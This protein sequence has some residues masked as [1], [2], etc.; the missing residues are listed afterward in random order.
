MACKESM[1]KELQRRLALRRTGSIDLLS[2]L[3]WDEEA[4]G[5]MDENHVPRETQ[6]RELFEDFMIR[7]ERDMRY[8]TALADSIENTLG[9]QRPPPAPMSKYER[10]RAMEL[11]R[12]VIE[13]AK[14]EARMDNAGHSQFSRSCK[15][16]IG[17]KEVRK[18]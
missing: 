2:N 16:F 17:F 3:G 10:Q 15:A 13:A 18:G 14:A 9:W 12:A 5:I 4:D 11:E 7:F 8:R 6:E 1:W